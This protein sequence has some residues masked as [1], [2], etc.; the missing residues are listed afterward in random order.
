MRRI[1]DADFACDSKWATTLTK[2]T[3]FALQ[4]AQ[5][6]KPKNE[7]WAKFIFPAKNLRRIA[8]NSLPLQLMYSKNT[9]LSEWQWKG[10]IPSRN[11]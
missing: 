11:V 10:K 3:V 8:I 4:S 5:I 7:M 9:K 1:D 2:L 6:N